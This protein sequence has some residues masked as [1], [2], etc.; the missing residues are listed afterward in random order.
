MP[1]YVILNCINWITH[2]HSIALSAEGARQVADLASESHSLLLDKSSAIQNPSTGV[3]DLFCVVV[4]PTVL[5]QSSARLSF[6]S[7]SLVDQSRKC[8]VLI[9]QGHQLD[10]LLGTANL[11]G[12][13]LIS[14]WFW[15]PLITLGL[16]SWLAFVYIPPP[17]CVR[18]SMGTSRSRD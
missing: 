8:R 15:R 16:N 12:R 5:D 17:L 13:Q 2:I 4:A 14:V 7:S 6:E 10:S 18:N 9:W 1:L 11:T 3:R